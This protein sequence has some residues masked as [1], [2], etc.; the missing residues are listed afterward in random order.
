MS[1]AMPHGVKGIT[2]QRFGRAVV[3]EFAG[4]EDRRAWWW[5]KCD[6]GVVFIQKGTLLRN[7]AAGSHRCRAMVDATGIKPI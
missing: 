4:T 7:G 1:I 3:Q 6:C 5:C 2:G